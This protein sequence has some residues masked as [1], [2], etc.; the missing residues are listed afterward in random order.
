M[1]TWLTTRPGPSDLR[2]RLASG[3]VVLGTFVKSADAGSTEILACAGFD[4]LVADLE[5]SSLVIADVE[6]ITRAAAVHGV[7][8]LARIGL[9][10]LGVAGRILDTGIAGIQLTDVASRRSLAAASA[11]IRFPPAG[12]RSLSLSHRAARYGHLPAASF[13]RE[14]DE[15]VL[16]VAQIESRRG[17]AAL[18]D[19]LA[20]PVLPDAWFLGPVDLSNDLGHPGEDGHPE[21]QAA[22]EGIVASLSA[23]AARLGV[24]AR[25]IKQA[26]SWIERGATFIVVSSDVMLL[27]GAARQVVAA[28]REAR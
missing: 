27:A 25:D 10:D 9:H 5:H 22:F 12:R 21:V 24:F 28:W 16:I 18:D 3:E 14:A 7:P 15:G 2:S 17:A 19:M 26:R 4:F 8:V 1:N 23:K 20:A 11:A 6:S 13:V